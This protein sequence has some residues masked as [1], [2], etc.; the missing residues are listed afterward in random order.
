M[1]RA[2]KGAMANTKVPYKRMKAKATKSPGKPQKRRGNTS[3][4]LDALTTQCAQR[5]NN[6]AKDRESPGGC[7]ALKNKNSGEEINGVKVPDRGT[8]KRVGPLT[9]KCQHHA[10]KAYRNDEAPG[11]RNAPVG[12][13]IIN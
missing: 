12:C 9:G 10:R 5:D 8:R 11:R 3:G 4:A 1:P 2:Q 13:R 7:K 6:T